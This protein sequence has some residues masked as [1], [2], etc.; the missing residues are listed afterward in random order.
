MPSFT[1]SSFPKIGAGLIVACVWTSIAAAEPVRVSEGTITVPTYDH[2]RRDMQPPLFEGSSGGGMYPFTTYLPGWRPGDPKPQTYKTIELENEY[3]KL[4]YVPEFGGRIFSLYDKVAR[5]EVFYRNEVIKPAHYNPRGSW[6]Q[7]GM[8]LTGPHDLHMLTLHGEPF[9][10]NRVVR[11]S[12][13]GA[14]LYISEVDPVYHMKVNLTATLH[15]GVAALEMGVFCY[16]TRDGRMPQMFWL[17]SA[18]PGTPKTEFIYPMTRTIGHTTSEIA[19][20]PVYNGVDYR[21][22]R[23]NKNMLGVFGIDIYDDFQGAYQHDSDYGVFRYADRRIVQGM[24]MWTFGYGPSSK[25]YERG[26]TDKTGPYVEV[27][28]GRMVWDGHYEWVQPHKFENWSERWVPVSG[29]GGLTTIRRDVALHLEIKDG[30]VKVGLSAARPLPG[31]KISVQSS[32]G[33]I[34]STTADLAPGKPFNQSVS[35][36][37][38]GLREVVVTVADRSGQELLRYARPDSNPGRIEYTPFTRALEKPARTP[39]QMSIEE[40]VLG[41]EFKLKELKD[42]PAIELLDKALAMDPGYS[43]AHLLLGIH[44]FNSYS[45][46]KAIEHLEKAIERDPYLDEAYYYLSVAQIKNGQLAKAERNLYY[47]WPGSGY[48]PDREYNLVRI[49]YVGGKL[50]GEWL[51]PQRP[52][53]A[54][55]AGPPTGAQGGRTGADCRTGKAGSHQRVGAVGEMAAQRRQGRGG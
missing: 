30:A 28:S 3:L 40:L 35:T 7:S 17:S 54:R 21:W 10:S 32:A 41:A 55:A 37:T 24:K 46:P 53:H 33:G 11:Q 12:D 22:D 39:E 23:N 1:F 52:G 13:G 44:A 50:A 9:W 25:M 49:A 5:R 31:V 45:Y 6:Q 16:N 47:I 19:D 43:R 29:I 36:S 8:E 4:T 20:W 51:P 14:T 2:P 34:L 15:P 38:D 27:Q 26:Y 18:L 42:G 48:Y